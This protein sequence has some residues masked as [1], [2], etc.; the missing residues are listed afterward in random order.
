MSKKR[1]VEPLWIC[2]DESP[3]RLVNTNSID[4]VEET[5]LGVKIYLISGFCFESKMKLNDFM[6]CINRKV[7]DVSGG[8]DS[9]K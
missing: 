4:Y 5:S 9:S 1:V 2:L 7:G 8:A 6:D 3:K